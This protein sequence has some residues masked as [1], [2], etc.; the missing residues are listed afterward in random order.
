MR[1]STVA[2]LRQLLSPAELEVGSYH[3][4]WLQEVSRTAALDWVHSPQEYRKT[5]AAALP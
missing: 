5:C 3:Y 2:P 4:W 1:T